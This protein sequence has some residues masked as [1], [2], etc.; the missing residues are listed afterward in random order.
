M[1]KSNM[2]FLALILSVSFM[3]VGCETENDN[4]EA[5]G[6]ACLDNASQST[7]QTCMDLVEGVTSSKASLVRCGSIYLLQG[8]TTQTFTNAF[9][10]LKSPP[11][12]QNTTLA[13]MSYVSFSNTG[14]RNPTNDANFAL[15]ECQKSGSGGLAWLASSTKVATLLNVAGGGALTPGDAASFEGQ[16]GSVP[17]ADLGAAALVAYDSYCGTGSAAGTAACEE[18]SA[19]VAQGGGDAAS[20]GAALKTLLANP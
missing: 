14:G 2:V 13:M 11:A 20:I 12:G 6:Q 18:F 4:K 15:S 7:A 9:D 1:K 17:D 3:S 5:Q 10:A 16:L 8:F 19:A